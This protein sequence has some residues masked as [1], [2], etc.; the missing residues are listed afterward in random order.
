MDL[1]GHEHL[2]QVHGAVMDLVEIH[3][4]GGDVTLVDRT[5]MQAK[6]VPG[7]TSGGAQSGLDL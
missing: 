3:S 1:L 4:Q 5:T 2:V 7:S 6:V